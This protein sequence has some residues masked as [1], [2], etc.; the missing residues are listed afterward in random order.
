MPDPH[1]TPDNELASAIEAII[2]SMDRPVKS[3]KIIEALSLTGKDAPKRIDAA[4]EDLNQ[5]YESTSRPFRIERV[6]GGFRAMLT[7]SAANASSSF[8]AAR[9]STKLSKAAIETLAIVAYRQPITRAELEAIRG[10]ACGEIL[11]SLLERRLITITGRAEEVGRPMLYGTSK[12][13][14]EVF[15]IS[16]IKDLPPVEGFIAGQ[17]PKKSKPA[18]KPADTQTEQAAAEDVP[19]VVVVEGDTNETQHSKDSDTD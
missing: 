11:R 17:R 15:G 9:E 4:I 7:A 5:T 6:A 16:S 14:L 19:Q 18:E 10:V 2:L 1:T 12:R 3:A 13:F 8:H